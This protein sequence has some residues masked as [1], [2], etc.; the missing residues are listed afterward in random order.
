MGILLIGIIVLITVSLRSCSAEEETPKTPPVVQTPGD[1]VSLGAS[2]AA[3][4]DYMDSILY[5][6]DSRTVG[7]SEYGYLPESR[8]LAETGLDHKTART[9]AFLTL[10][11]EKVTIAQAVQKLEPQIQLVSFGING[12]ATLTEEEF[13]SE[14]KGLISDLR[15]AAPESTI[16]VQS[17]L[18]VTI[19]YAVDHPDTNNDKIARYNKKLVQLCIENGCYYLNTADGLRAEGDN[20]LAAKYA[21][22]DG[23]HINADAYELILRYIEEHPAPLKQAES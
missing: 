16:I 14:F 9:K 5:I 6:G 13:F 3:G 12:L 10:D 7:L 15:T 19:S 21:E 20:A 22:Q 17:I 11:G 8:V 1:E 23:L 2:S 4:A 18:P